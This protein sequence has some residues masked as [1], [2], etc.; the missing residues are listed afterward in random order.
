MD[1]FAELWK[2]AQAAGPL[3]AGL[4]LFLWWDERKDKK[5]LQVKYDAV[6]ERALVLHETTKNVLDRLTNVLTPHHER[7]S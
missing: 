1:I 7:K 4:F 5:A 3:G 2:L 6:F